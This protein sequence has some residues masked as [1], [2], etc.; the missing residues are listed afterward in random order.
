MEPGPGAGAGR[1]GAE[2]QCLGRS[3]TVRDASLRRSEP[4]WRWRPHW[5][6]GLCPCGARALQ[7][8]PPSRPAMPPPAPPT[9]LEPSERAVVLLSCVLSAIGSGLLV[10]THALWPDLRSRA[11]RLLLFL[12]LADLLSAASYFY[13]VLQDFA[14]PSWD[15]VLQGA[16]STFAN[17]SSFFWTVAIALYLYLSIVRAVRGPRAGHLLWAFHVVRWRTWGTFSFLCFAS[18]A[19]WCPA[20]S[21]KMK[22]SPNVASWNCFLC[23]W[24]VPLVITVAAVSLKKIGYDASDVSVGWCWIDLEAEDRV[25]WMLL[26]GKLWEMLAYVTLPVL[27]L[28]IRK[29][30]N[31]AVGD[32]TGSPRPPAQSYVATA[33]CGLAPGSWPWGRPP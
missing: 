5:R 4:S 20:A 15:C 22:I 24:G 27:Y 31:R 23:Y 21:W 6:P 32:P 19:Q 1:R 29:H 13:G 30:I 16:L 11:R 3:G 7:P 18:S 2:A 33:Q 14:G 17:T 12:S 25:L 26:T 9:E 10:A 28:L 8:R